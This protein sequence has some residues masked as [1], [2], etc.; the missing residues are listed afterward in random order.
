MKHKKK[1]CRSIEGEKR[2]I[3]ALQSPEV[4]AKI[5]RTLKGKDPKNRVHLYTKLLNKRRSLKLKGVSRMQCG[6]RKEKHWNW[7]KDKIRIC[8]KCSKVITKGSKKYRC[9]K[10][11]ILEKKKNKLPIEHFRLMKRLHQ[12]KRLFKQKSNG[13]CD[14]TR[15]EW[16]EIIK[17]SK[18]ICK[19]CNLKK[20]LTID[21]IIPLSKGGE[22]T[23]TNIQA[24]C[25]SCNVKKSNHLP[26]VDEA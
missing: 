18:G 10:C 22:H 17:N 7:K 25:L 13:R 14:F 11:Y 1:Y 26:L 20:E 5:S 6:S 15:E 23:K 4:R 12:S 19:N 9:M 16:L 24:I 21:H 2:R 3:K 8:I